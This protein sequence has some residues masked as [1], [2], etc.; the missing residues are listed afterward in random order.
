MA[1]IPETKTL[2]IFTKAEIERADGKDGRP[3]L[4]AVDGKVYDVS[5]S[6][7]WKAGVHVNSHHA[8]EDLSLA[9]KAAPHAA[10]VLTNLD[11]VGTVLQEPREPTVAPGSSVFR[12]LQGLHLHPVS[13]H[14]PIALSIAAAAS[15]AASLIVPHRPCQVFTLYCLILAA[16]A[17]PVAIASGL[18]SWYCSYSAIWTRLYRAKIVLSCVLIALQ[19]G[20][21]VMR[22]GIVTDPS[23]TSPAYCAY[24][25]L[26]L[27]TAPAVVALGYLGGKL[28][29]P[30]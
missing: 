10:D 30:S 4:V 29:F 26:V 20:A 21:L 8:G 24:A 18:L 7:F 5:S 28:T 17:T 6:K 15:M 27:A 25:V 14:F 22:L 2:R 1:I 16:L 23:L 19:I 3:A 12:R 13:V 9:L 11:L